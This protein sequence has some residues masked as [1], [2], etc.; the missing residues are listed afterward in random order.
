MDPLDTIQSQLKTQLKILR[1]ILR[2]V[3]DPTGEK[4]EQRSRSNGFSKSMTLSREMA[5]FMGRT[6]QGP[7]EASR[8]DVT[9]FLNEYINQKN[10]KDPS[11]RRVI[12]MDPPLTKLMEPPTGKIIT[13][14]NIQTLL[15]PHLS[16]TT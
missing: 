1:K 10:L 9:K 5:R 13:F 2:V 14:L 8:S 4:R 15:T 16:K 12:L 11:D 3:E 7:H 6:G